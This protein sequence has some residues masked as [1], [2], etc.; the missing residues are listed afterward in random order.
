MYTQLPFTLGYDHATAAADTLLR[1][2]YSRTPSTAATDPR[3]VH[4]GLDVIADGPACEH[5]R[6]PLPVTAGWDQGF[7][8]SENGEVL[9]AQMRVDEPALDNMDHAA[10]HA[11]TR[12]NDF[13]RARRY[14]HLLRTWNYFHDIHRGSGDRE[15]YRQFVSG[16]YRAL[17]DNPD[18]E[19]QL[20]AATAIGSHEPG[21][22][23]YFL[24]GKTAGM[25]IENPRQLSAFQYPQQYG[26]R[27]PSFSRATLVRSETATCLLVSGT[28]SIVG[29]AT[30]HAGDAAAQF[31][32][33]R[34]NLHALLDQATLACAGSTPAPWRAQSFKLY[35]RTPHL[36]LSLRPAVDELAG[37]ADVICV[38]GDV[39]RPDLLAEI[40]AVYQRGR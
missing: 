14:P 26:P 22:L 3:Q 34:R 10:F 8:Y 11:Y 7:G 17:A 18:F 21:M 25:Q 6:S 35:L 16:R 29:H 28:A 19:R 40:E 30:Q 37:G 12:I 38:T 24:A 39:C 20:P 32:E 31:A 23:I 1:V 13:L 2:S 27:S 33:I 36:L 4:V 5:W 15:R 9:F